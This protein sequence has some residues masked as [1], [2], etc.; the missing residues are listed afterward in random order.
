MLD[1]SKTGGVSPPASG[2]ITLAAPASSDV[3][4]QQ[5]LNRHSRRGVSDSTIQLGS[6]AVSKNL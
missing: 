3:V 2:A 5:F 4:F 1:L 6:G